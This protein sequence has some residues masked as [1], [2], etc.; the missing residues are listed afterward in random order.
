MI[1]PERQRASNVQA[2]PE[3]HLVVPRD[4]RK[5]R[6]ADRVS[7]KVTLLQKERTLKVQMIICPETRCRLDDPEASQK[8]TPKMTFG[9]NRSIGRS[10][11]CGELALM[12]RR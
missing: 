10:A 8:M 3:R 12:K 6:K 2:D 7:L 1:S 9:M 11:I 4:P 5:A